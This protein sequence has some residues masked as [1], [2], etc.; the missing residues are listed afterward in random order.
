MALET[1]TEDSFKPV[2]TF[3]QVALWVASPDDTVPIGH[4]S[5][6]T[7]VPEAPRVAS[8]PVTL[9]S[10]KSTGDDIRALPKEVLHLQGEMNRIMGWLLTTRASMDACQRKEVSNFQMALYQNEAQTTEIIREAEAVH[11]TAVRETK[12]NCVNI[13]QHAE[14]KCARTIREVKTVSTEHACT[15]QQAHRDSMED[16]EREAIEE[17]E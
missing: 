8:I 14:G 13:I 15:L 3:P 7:P 12:A 17:D 9:P 5:A 1:R 16:L 4:L 2:A 11:A 6:M 10:K